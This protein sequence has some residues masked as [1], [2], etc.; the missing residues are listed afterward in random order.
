VPDT[1]SFNNLVNTE[2]NSQIVSN[3]IIVSGIN[4]AI[5]LS[6]NSGEYSINSGAWNS[7]NTIIN[8]GDKIKLR[9][10]SS[11]SYSTQSNIV[12]NL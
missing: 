9:L 10:T 8:N 5:S 3:E 2:L 7:S 6:I 1:F 12:I 11:S 4:S